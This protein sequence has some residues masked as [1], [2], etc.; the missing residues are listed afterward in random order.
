[1]PTES[2]FTLIVSRREFIHDRV[3]LKSVLVMLIL[4]LSPATFNFNDVYNGK[5]I[6][7]VSDAAGLTCGKSGP[8]INEFGITGTK[9]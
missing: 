5:K 4:L 7:L 8:E 3:P 1:L 2:Y 6:L 9:T